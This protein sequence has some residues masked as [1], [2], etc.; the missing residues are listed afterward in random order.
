MTSAGLAGAGAGAGLPASARA[1]LRPA[2]RAAARARTVHPAAWWIWGIGTAA[3]ASRTT[4]PVVLGLLAVAVLNVATARRQPGP[5]GRAVGVFVR[6]GLF[7]ILLRVVLTVLIGVRTPGTVLFRLPAVD[8]P[9]WAAGISLGGPVTAEALLAA[10]Y[11][12]LQLAVIL[13]CFGAVNAMASAYRLLR[14]LPPVLHEAGVAV[15]VAVT[16]APQLVVSVGR[17]RA[18]RRLRGRPGGW[19]GV[20]GSVMPVLEEALERSV[21]LAA[22]MDV[23]GYGRTAAVAP[24]RRAVARWLLLIGL[25]GLVVGSYALLDAATPDVLRLPLVAIGAAAVV[26]GTVL[27]GRRARRT[28]HRPDPWGAPEWATALSGVASAALMSAAAAGG[29]LVPPVAPPGWP[30]MSLVALA[31]AAMVLVPLVATPPVPGLV[32]EPADRPVGSAR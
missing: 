8:L 7:V 21:R 24:Q 18:A 1:G 13:G 9:Q 10:V 15:A 11:G 26:A 6:M 20:A 2:A 30:P 25:V 22:S 32:P 5:A 3:A 17:V 29:A 12:G 19:R 27:A 16:L 4:N 14:A 23:R 31:A 28:V